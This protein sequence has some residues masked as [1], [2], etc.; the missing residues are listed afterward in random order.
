[1]EDPVAA[2]QMSRAET[3]LSNAVEVATDFME[4]AN[5]LEKAEYM[6]L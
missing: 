3:F 6:K 4:W 2:L 1:M 5:A